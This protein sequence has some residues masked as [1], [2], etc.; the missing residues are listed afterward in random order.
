M[1]AII[2]ST[3]IEQDSTSDAPWITSIASEST[4][5]QQFWAFQ[6]PKFEPVQFIPKKD[7]EKI[8]SLSVLEASAVAHE[9]LGNGGNHWTF[10]LTVTLNHLDPDAS[11][12]I[13]LDCTP[14]GTP[15]GGGG[16]GSKA[17]IVISLLED[18]QFSRAQCICRLTTRQPLKVSDLVDAVFEHGKEKYD[19]DNKGRGCKK[20]VAEQMDLFLEVGIITDQDEVQSAKSEMMFQWEKFKH[21]GDHSMW[22]MG[23]YYQ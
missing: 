6:P 15:A 4:S 14:S 12:L 3:S 1:A 18:R 16:E 7:R 20:W 21:T 17:N 10:Y 22:A 9:P 8:L 23:S 13:Q 2:Q 5:T 19:F 11:R